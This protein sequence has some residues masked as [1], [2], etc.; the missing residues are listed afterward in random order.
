[1]ETKFTPLESGIGGVEAFG[2]RTMQFKC[3]EVRQNTWL[4][5]IATKGFGC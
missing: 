3:D 5:L 2:G 1:M 4:L